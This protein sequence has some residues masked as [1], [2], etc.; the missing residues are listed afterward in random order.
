MNV[1]RAPDPASAPARAHVIVVGNHKGGAGKSTVAMHVA[2]ALMRMGRR[3]GAIDLDV[4]QRSLTRYV[5]N[6]ARA[7]A[8]RDARLPVP[9]MLELRASEARALDAAEAEEEASFCAAIR[10][11]SETCEFIVL[12]APGGDRHLARLAH[13]SADTLITPLN[14]SFIDF[15][16]LGDIGGAGD[17]AIRPSIYSEMVWESRKR[18]AAA[19]RT[20]I[21]WVVMRNRTSTSRIEAKNTHK[22][23]D[24]LKTLS[25]RIGFRLAPGLSERVIFRELF[26]DGLTL[27]DLGEAAKGD[28]RMAHLA[29]RQEV[30]DLFIAL[31]LPGLEGEPLR[32]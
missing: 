18:K 16:L 27:L 11:L 1:A 9:Q 12:D 3:T 26:P 17:D 14:D 30:R 20:P 7:N 2:V 21:D 19:A 22:V 24:A 25:G 32:F 23:G 10:R 4:T 6:R 15:D 13:A 8:V 28:L 29:A 31:K 5:E